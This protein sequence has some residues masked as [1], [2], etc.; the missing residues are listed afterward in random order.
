MTDLIHKR[1]EINTLFIRLSTRTSSSRSFFQQVITQIQSYT[2]LLRVL[3]KN[4]HKISVRNTDL[5]IQYFYVERWLKL[6]PIT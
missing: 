5:L 3:S 6:I 4:K 2:Q 1:N